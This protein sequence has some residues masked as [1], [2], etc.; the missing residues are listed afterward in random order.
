MKYEIELTE[1]EIDYFQKHFAKGEEVPIQKAVQNALSD[2]VCKKLTPK[3]IEAGAGFEAGY[4]R[5]RRMAYA[6]LVEAYNQGY[7][8]GYDDGYRDGRYD[9]YRKGYS[10]GTFDG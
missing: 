8:D 10:D 5:G 3:D 4:K 2:I 6:E 9:G 7:D 1:Q